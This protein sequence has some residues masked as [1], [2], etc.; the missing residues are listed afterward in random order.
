MDEFASVSLTVATPFYWLT[1]LPT[2]MGDWGE[3]VV[4]S[5]QSLLKENGSLRAE[6]RVLRAKLQKMASLAT[7]NVRLRELLNST[8]RLKDNVLVA[9]IIG[10]S[11]D[12]LSQHV[13]VN[14]GTGAGVYVG[15]PVIDAYGLFGQ[16]IDV[17]PISCRV[18]LITDSSHAV[19]IQ[20]NRNGVRA[21]AEGV[22]L[23]HEMELPHVAATTDIQESDIL[24]SSGLGARFPVGYPVATVVSVVR[25]PGKP[26]MKVKVMPKAHLNRSRHV[27]LVFKTEAQAFAE[28]VVG[29]E[30]K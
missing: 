24:V 4:I 27:L 6:Q 12:P 21:V 25:D 14:K 23:L 13:I 16:V 30:L 20:V 1:D 29:D 22:G 3:D 28:E 26:F 19:P 9:E 15:Q 8:A 10:I 11:P 5:R 17:S 2:R 7:E 18:L